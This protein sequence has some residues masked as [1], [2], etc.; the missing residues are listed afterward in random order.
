[1]K[2]SKHNITKRILQICYI[3][4]KPFIPFIVAF[5]IITFFIIL[6]I[7]A[8]FVEFSDENG[9]IAVDE[10][11]IEEYCESAN[12]DNYDVYVDGEKTS[13][14]IEIS[15]IEKSKAISEEQI[16]S[17]MIFHNIADNQEIT[18][19]MAKNIADEFKSKYYYKTSKIITEQKIVDEDGNTLW[20]VVNEKTVQLITESITI[21]G[22]Y[23][24]NYTEEVKEERKYKNNKRSIE[25]YCFS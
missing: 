13:E 9:E 8:I 3:L 11:E 2:K 15:S 21:A 6:I 23:Q 4:I 1:M 12:K 18:N 16:Y 19:E 7:D 24:Y 10:K 20:Q 22:H 5:F 14:H 25:K 17:L